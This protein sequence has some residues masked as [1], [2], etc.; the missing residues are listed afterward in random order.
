MV[1]VQK[2]TSLCKNVF[3][4]CLRET[5]TFPTLCISSSFKEVI[6]GSLLH[7]F[8]QFS[9]SEKYEKKRLTNLKQMVNTS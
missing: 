4:A 5:H 9:Q 3:Y 6:V 7:Q 8:L 2:R 1:F